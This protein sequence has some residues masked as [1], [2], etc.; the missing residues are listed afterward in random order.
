MLAIW[1]LL[2]GRVGRFLGARLRWRVATLSWRI[3]AL[4][5][6]VASWRGAGLRIRGRLIGHFFAVQESVQLGTY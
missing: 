4:G 3:A 6:R 1:Y 2:L 5:R